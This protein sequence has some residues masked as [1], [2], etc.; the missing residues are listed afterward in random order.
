LINLKYLENDITNIINTYIPTIALDWVKNIPGI[1]K[2]IKKSLF[3]ILFKSTN[4]MQNKKINNAILPNPDERGM[5]I[6]GIKLDLL[7]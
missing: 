2:K 6:T 7:E 1:T 3:L 5:F 4:V